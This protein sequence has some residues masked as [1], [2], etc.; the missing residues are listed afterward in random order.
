MCVCFLL[1]LLA[2]LLTAHDAR[3]YTDPVVKITKAV[4]KRS[5]KI[6]AVRGEDEYYYKQTLTGRVLNGENKGS[7]VTLHNEFSYSGVANTRYHRGNR[8]FATISGQAEDGLTGS[9]KGQKR[10]TYLVSLLGALLLLLFLITGKMGARTALTLIANITIY[11]VGFTLYRNGTDILSICNVMALLFTVGTMLILGGCNKK[12]WAA[13]LSSLAVLSLIMGMFVLVLNHAKE[14]DYSMMEYLGSLSHPESIFHAEVMLAGLGAIM[15]VSVTISAALAE[16]VRKKP[17]VKFIEL[18]RSGR[19]VGYDIMGTMMNVL[20][21]TFGCGLIPGFLIKMNNEIRFLTI[22][23]LHI[24]FEIC[25]FLIESIGIVAAI[26]V[27]ILIT[28]VFIKVRRK[29]A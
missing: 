18:F 3:L 1:Y 7:K 6:K 4:T 16:I 15:D 27:S 12:T 2:V 10:D 29:R 20:L 25:R 5:S 11:A 28:T 23:R 8:V 19:E 26:P 21:F 13:V 14:L 17:E 9:I 24:P 22:V